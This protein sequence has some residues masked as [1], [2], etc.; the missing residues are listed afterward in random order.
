MFTFL[1]IYFFF[2]FEGRYY[3]FFVTHP[4]QTIASR[5][6]VIVMY[7]VFTKKNTFRQ[8]GRGAFSVG[9]NN[10]IYAVRHN[11]RMLFY[12]SFVVLIF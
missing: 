9:T 6:W 4:C 11:A 7:E 8:N 5:H 12:L 3:F 1:F 10:N 2:F